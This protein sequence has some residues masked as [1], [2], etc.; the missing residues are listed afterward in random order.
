[1]ILDITY[2]DLTKKLQK[3]MIII[4]FIC[5]IIFVLENL[6]KTNLKYS[7]LKLKIFTNMVQ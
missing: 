2:S 5:H 7:R 6:R 4:N 1:M 3:I